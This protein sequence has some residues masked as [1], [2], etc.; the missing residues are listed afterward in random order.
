VRVYARSEWQKVENAALREKKLMKFD[1]CF[2]GF[3]KQ[4]ENE[5]KRET[6]NNNNNKNNTKKNKTKQT[7][8]NI[9]LLY[10]ST[11]IHK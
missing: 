7:D 2:L 5:R 6:K 4:K 9:S 11:R 1:G 8:I 10:L 3:F